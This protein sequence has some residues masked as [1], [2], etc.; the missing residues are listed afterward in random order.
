MN[1]NST[2]EGNIPLKE[3]DPS[4][5]LRERIMKLCERNPAMSVP[6]WL[7]YPDAIPDHHTFGRF[8]GAIEDLEKKH[9][10]ITDGGRTPETLF[11]LFAKGFIDGYVEGRMDGRN[12]LLKR[13]KE[14]ANKGVPKE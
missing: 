12:N 2:N 10:R 5:N 6:A 8:I 9:F 1:A 13:L 14:Q 4:R 7:R 3:I 11:N